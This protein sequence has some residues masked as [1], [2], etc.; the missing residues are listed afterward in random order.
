MISSRLSA[1]RQRCAL[2]ALTFVALT[3]VVLV[4]MAHGHLSGSALLFLFLGFGSNVAAA[5]RV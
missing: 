1:G 2:T 3:F 4:D 5:Y